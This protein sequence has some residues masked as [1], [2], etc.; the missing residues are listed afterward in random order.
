M[1]DFMRKKAAGWR[2][3][4]IALMSVAA[5][6]AG[7]VVLGE[8]GEAADLRPLSPQASYDYTVKK[9]IEGTAVSET[10]LETDRL[11]CPCM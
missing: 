6:L 8:E 10:L 5:L 7:G 11:V 4:A 9:D 1:V 2:L 3:P